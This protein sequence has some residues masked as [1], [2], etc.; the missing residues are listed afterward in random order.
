[1]SAK[2]KAAKGAVKGVA[3]A[4]KAGFK[5]RKADTLRKGLS[6]GAEKAPF[7]ERL[8]FSAGQHPL[9][10]AGAATPFALM[11]ANLGIDAGQGITDWL[12]GDS[13]AEKKR[14]MLELLLQNSGE[15]SD[16]LTN[17]AVYDEN[18]RRILQMRPDLAQ[19]LL[20][21]RRLPP[22]AQM[23]GGNPR[24]DLLEEIAMAMAQG[25]LPQGNADPISQ[26]LG[27]M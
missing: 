25:Q 18:T 11:G 24:T 23:F 9:M 10:T 1:M 27:G 12:T 6:T 3:K 20:A 19:N 8:A 13:D 15:I 22:G 17:Q 7:L 14:M 26:L 2:T 16:N 5:T 4:A 21:G